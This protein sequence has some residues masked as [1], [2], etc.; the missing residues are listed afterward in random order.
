MSYLD[1]LFGLKGK[2]AVI[3]GGGGV[4]AGSMADGL[5]Q[6]G[7]NIAIVDINL[8]LAKH[9]AEQLAKRGVETLALM[10][11]ASQKSALQS[12]SQEIDA[13]FGHVDILINAPGIN[14]MTPFFE[15][16]ESEWDKI[17]D[18][19]L[20]SMFFAC[21]IFGRRM[22]DQGTGGSIINISSASSGP[23]LSKV[24]TYS[25]SKAGV[26]NLTQYLAR[27]WAPY[28]IRVNAIAPGF[29]PA[30]QNRKILTEDRI[31]QIFNHTPMA[32][33]GDPAELIGAVIWLA[34]DK[35][36]SFVTGAIIRVDGG[37]SAMTI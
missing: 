6:A 25:I 7:A 30:E 27:E 4:L 12:V 1:E 2:T 29:F 10:A 18:V 11:D 23:P 28:H 33:F 17:L 20:K 24:F 22:I 26:N 21:Q 9:R 34:S 14:S 13:V 8:E 15:I 32:R 31:A 19:N 3:I 37:F 16:Q 35:A 5:A 36:S